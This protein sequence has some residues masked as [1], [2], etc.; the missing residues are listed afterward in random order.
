M[1]S[2]LDRR[3]ALDQQVCLFLRLPSS[4]IRPS[5]FELNPALSLLVNLVEVDDEG[6]PDPD[7]IIPI[8]DGGSEGPFILSLYLSI[9]AVH[10]CLSACI[11]RSM[12]ASLAQDSGDRRA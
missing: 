4:L 3:K 6:N 10:F 1:R 8:V 2:G 5:C 7:T 12:R 9:S 11:S